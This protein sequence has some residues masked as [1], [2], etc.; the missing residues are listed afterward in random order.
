VEPQQITT[1]AAAAAAECGLVLSVSCRKWC[2]QL[3]R[4]S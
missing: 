3:Y 1:T 2:G 4:K